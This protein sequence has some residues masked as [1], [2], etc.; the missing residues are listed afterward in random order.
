[1]I[2]IDHVSFCYSKHSPPVVDNF[3]LSVNRGES[4]CIIGPNGSGKSTLALLVAGLLKPT[5]G[6]VTINQ[7]DPKALPVGILFQ[8]P[9]NQ[10][11]AA[12]VER[13]IAFGLENHGTPVDKMIELVNEVLVRFKLDSLRHRL[14]TELSG[15]EKQRV[16]L[17][18]LM[19]LK[20]DILVLDE[21][22]SF[23]D[24]PGKAILREELGR[25]R[26]SHPNLI[27]LRITQYPEV[28]RQYSRLIIL[29]GGQIVA[30]GEPE[31]ILKDKEIMAVAGFGD[32]GGEEITSDCENA[33]LTRA[34]IERCRIDVKNVSF[35][36]NEEKALFEKL[37][38]SVKSG[39]VLGVV[40]P[41]GSGKS[42]L[43]LL[44][45]GLLKP[46]EGEIC[47]YQDDNR[48]LSSE[49]VL[50]LISA[51]LQQPERQFFLP[52]VLD[53][54]EFGPANI[55][56]PVSPD[57]LSDILTL[58]GLDNRSHAGRDPFHLSSGEKRRLAFG[59]VLAMAP[60][61]IFFDEPTCALDGRGVARFVQLSHFLK[62][63]GVGQV[64]ISHDESIIR[65]LADSVLSLDGRS[66]HKLQPVERHFQPM[67][68]KPAPI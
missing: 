8:N 10:M 62:K 13:E 41:T 45:S 26:R 29:S 24:S 6:T 32:P 56:R 54:L 44:M 58:V 40:G 43:V 23:L 53:E 61:L 39:E 68:E 5:S 35:S 60:G 48:S 67:P 33:T 4:V 50:R 14:T 46:T 16:A 49:K 25:I 22:D 65:T 36:R 51:V 21:P 20:P 30:D 9:D 42:T 47:Y 17:A 28:A 31:K 64:V 59:V 63:L 66:G 18:S 19:V 38:F 15:G 2:K 1:M 3:S 27:E 34:D 7:P 37:S 57:T 55:G 11:V 12:T 52:T